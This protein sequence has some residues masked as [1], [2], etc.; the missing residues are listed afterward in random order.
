LLESAASAGN[1]A[2]RYRLARQLFDTGQADE[3]LSWLKQAADAGYA[4]AQYEYA[5]RVETD[6][7]DLATVVAY[8]GMAADRGHANAQAHLMHLKSL[9]PDRPEL[10]SVRPFW[11]HF[12]ENLAPLDLEVS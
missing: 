5:R 9:H 6:P 7:D 10:L 3:A 12:E 1:S 4:R 8:L 11:E 2:A